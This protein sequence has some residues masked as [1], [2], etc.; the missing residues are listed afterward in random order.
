L[1]TGFKVRVLLEIVDAD[2]RRRRDWGKVA[3]TVSRINPDGLA[4]VDRVGCAFLDCTRGQIT[5]RGRVHV[6]VAIALISIIAVQ[7]LG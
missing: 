3:G 2:S 4:H 6:R 5:R 1:G 7:E